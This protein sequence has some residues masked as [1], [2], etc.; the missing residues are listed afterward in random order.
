MKLLTLAAVLV[1][2]V[3]SQA[4]AGGLQTVKVPEPASLSLL[5]AGLGGLAV[6][7]FCRRRFK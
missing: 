4:W 3:P 2:L 1:T 7:R 6:F 5:A